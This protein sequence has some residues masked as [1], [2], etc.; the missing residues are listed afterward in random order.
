MAVIDGGSST[1]NKAN[2]DTG[3]NLH[4]TLPNTHAYVG[5]VRMHSEN[6]RGQHTGTPYLKSPD[7]SLDYRLRTGVDTVLFNDVF[8]A[9]LQNTSLW[10][11]TFAT[12]TAA[13]PG[14]GTV[15]FSAVQGTT[16]AH[17]A[18]MRTFQYFPLVNT[19]PLA[20]EFYFGQFTAQ[21]VSNEVWLMG[22]GLPTAATTIPTDGVWLRLSTSGLQGVI[23]FNGGLTT[24]SFT[25]A[26]PLIDFATNTMYK[27][28]IVIGEREVEYWIDDV[29]IGVQDIPADNGV[30][31]LSGSQP[32]FM[33]KYN[34]GSVS[35]TNTMRV[36]RLGVTLMDVATSKPWAE[37]QS[38]MGMNAAVL[39]NGMNATTVVPTTAGNTNQVI[40]PTTQAGSNSAPNSAMLGLGGQFLMTAQATNVAAA[41][42]M[43]G[44]SY[45]NPVPSIN[46]TGR[47]LYITG[48]SISCMNAGAA[49]ATTPTTLVWGLAWG[50]TNVSLATLETG[51]F[52]TATTHSPRRIPLGM[53]SA[54]VGAVIGALYDRDIVRTFD[55]PIV[56]RPG[57]FIATTVRFRI[58][59]ATAS[60]EV[61]YTV[62][63][64]GYWE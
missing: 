40:L 43:I 51:T 23:A 45:A 10:S 63:F 5:S 64:N 53:C 56:V 37:A 15:N 2:V 16:S 36:S 49:V 7:T 35:N 21:M 57:E 48:V 31:W 33:M 17:G 59:T 12:L 24:T 28:L 14:A 29:L 41:G 42:D 47:N 6:D 50:H 44:C 22:I 32:A 60:Q 58:G 1:V 54:P 62:M 25:V 38:G 34:T 39:Q 3:Y 9:T 26:K 4:V 46:I 19:A 27:A 18:F 55:A 52:V 30:P 61:F 20:I 13:Q 8:N 11:Y